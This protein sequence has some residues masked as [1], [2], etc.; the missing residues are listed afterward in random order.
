MEFGPLFPYQYLSCWKSNQHVFFFLPWM[1][2]F[3]LLSKKLSIVPM[4]AIYIILCLLS[5]LIITYY[6][7]ASRGQQCLLH[8][9]LDTGRLISHSETRWVT[10]QRSKDN[11]PSTLSK[12]HS[13][14]GLLLSPLWEGGR[15]I[16]PKADSIHKNKF[17]TLE[18]RISST[19]YLNLHRTD[20]TSPPADASHPIL[21]SYLK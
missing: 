17:A 11:E 5:S 18:V 10:R 8:P 14:S 4:A 1:E 3:F 13:S 16:V 7:H 19:I 6:S 2:H 9:D 21:L 20:A 15:P 12:K